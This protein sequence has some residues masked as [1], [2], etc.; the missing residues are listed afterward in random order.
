MTEFGERLLQAARHVGAGESQTEIAETLGLSKQT[1]HHWFTK[2]FPTVDNLALIERKWG[3]N[4][5]WLRT[6]DGQMLAT[7]DGLPEDELKLL[8]EY[9]KASAERRPSIIAVVAAMRKAIVTIAALLPGFMAPK[10]AE[11]FTI[12]GIATPPVTLQAVTY[13][14]ALPLTVILIAYYRI[15]QAIHA[16]EQYFSRVIESTTAVSQA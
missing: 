13:L 8:R 11:A 12:I 7:P 1:V 15:R 2:G 10:D 14:L 4:G 3:I 16:M 6:G 9:R 5:E